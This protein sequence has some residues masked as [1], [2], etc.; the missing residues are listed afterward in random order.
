M[1]R[2]FPHLM[3]AVPVL[4]V[5]CLGDALV[6]HKRAMPAL[7]C[8][9]S[10]GFVSRP[11]PWVHFDTGTHVGILHQSAAQGRLGLVRFFLSHGHAIDERDGNGRT[12]LHWAAATGELAAVKYLVGQGANTNARCE[13][14][15]TPVHWAVLNGR[16]SVLKF[17]IDRGAD[18]EAR[19]SR[20]ETPLHFAAGRGNL[21]AAK[22]L[23]SRGAEVDAYDVTGQTPLSRTVQKGHFKV[24]GLLL[25]SGAQANSSDNRGK[26]ALHYAAALGSPSLAGLL[27]TKGAVID[28]RDGKG[29]TPL[30]LAAEGSLSD[31]I[32]D[33]RYPDVVALLIARGADINARDVEGR[34]P[35][36][37]AS[38]AGC[39]KTVELLLTGGA[40]PSI[41]DS[42]GR[43]PLHA[44]AS[45]GED[46][47]PLEVAASLIEHGARVDAAD[48]RSVQPAQLAALSGGVSL[49]RFFLRCGAKEP[50]CP[51]RQSALPGWDS[52]AR[53]L[54]VL[55]YSF[56]ML[57]ATLGIY[58][59]LPVGCALLARLCLLTG[60][61]ASIVVPRLLERLMPPDL[62]CLYAQ[63]FPAGIAACLIVR[64][65]GQAIRHRYRSI[66]VHTLLFALAGG[67]V[68]PFAAV[69]FTFSDILSGSIWSS[70]AIGTISGT[71]LVL[72]E[73]VVSKQA[74]GKNAATVP[75]LF[76][77]PPSPRPKIT[78]RDLFR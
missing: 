8:S 14:G 75:A 27:L 28:V 59:Y 33:R 1:A 77:P 42:G 76:A 70:L 71:C 63:A 2:R 54:A 29:V 36:Y 61:V 43:T 17:L 38:A 62:F 58:R 52:C 16:L 53:M 19:T 56:L 72:H 31:P 51:Y 30:H 11:R 50:D 13:S 47:A 22:L 18:L 68:F 65:L 23:L 24:A 74:P 5:L 78:V 21:S 37:R 44:V 7:P 15:L 66:S 34:T 32:E 73:Q 46:A 12:P 55:V 9:M 41:G 60:I 64:R 48:R 69:F 40:D 3:L 10:G 67:V 6:L 20:G 49:V 26:T 57:L 25:S 35:L 45:L 39:P 4:A